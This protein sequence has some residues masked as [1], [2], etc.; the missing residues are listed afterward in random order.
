MSFSDDIRQPSVN[1]KMNELNSV[2]HGYR[3]LEFR[4]VLLIEIIK[5]FLI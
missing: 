4:S 3:S 2:S 5:T 1:H